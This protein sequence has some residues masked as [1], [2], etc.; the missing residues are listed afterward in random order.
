MAMEIQTL[1]L[2]VEG[3]KSV[4]EM[5]HISYAEIAEENNRTREKFVYL[6]THLLV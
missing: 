6:Q 3:P 5:V 2:F 1:G 4:S